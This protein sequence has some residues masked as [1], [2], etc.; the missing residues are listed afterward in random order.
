MGFVMEKRHVGEGG[1]DKNVTLASHGGGGGVKNSEK[2][3]Y[4]IFERSLTL[5]FLRC[6]VFLVFRTDDS[7][8][9]SE[10][11]YIFLLLTEAG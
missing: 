2:Q 8:C 3:R 7:P 5:V 11:V 10:I 9:V 6:V 1:F 4:V